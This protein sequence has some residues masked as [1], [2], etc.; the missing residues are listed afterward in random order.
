MEEIHA[1]CAVLE[2]IGNTETVVKRRLREMTGTEVP[3]N[4]VINLFRRHAGVNPVEHD[5][6]GVTI[7]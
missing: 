2:R 4:D 1:H 3:G 7:A 6:Y 5:L